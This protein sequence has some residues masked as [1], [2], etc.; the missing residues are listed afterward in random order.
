MIEY[1]F[2]FKMRWEDVCFSDHRIIDS[3]KMKI[4]AVNIIRGKFSRQEL[5]FCFIIPRYL[6]LFC[7][8]LTCV[9]KNGARLLVPP[10]PY[11]F[12]L[13]WGSRIYYVSHWIFALSFHLIDNPGIICSL[14]S[15]LALHIFRFVNITISW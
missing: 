8:C 4:G 11:K 7:T 9:L 10:G 14:A 15:I 5:V 2:I 13:L 6:G 3:R 12:L 1:V